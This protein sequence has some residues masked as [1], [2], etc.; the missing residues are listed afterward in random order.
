M[1]WP[2]LLKV[3]TT[4]L[5]NWRAHVFNQHI[6]LYLRHFQ[7]S[8]FLVSMCVCVIQDTHTHRLKPGMF[9]SHFPHHFLETASPRP[10]S[11]AVLPLCPS[12]FLT[13]P[14]RHCG[15]TNF[16]T[17]LGM[18]TWALTLGSEHS[19]KQTVSAAPSISLFLTGAHQG[20]R[21]TAASFLLAA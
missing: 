19:A 13:Q 21:G 7:E 4:R 20:S 11:S 12:L 3:V 6:L 18:G 17:D 16:Y 10:W 2:F 5:R 14:P 8:H 1:Y 9:P 15:Y